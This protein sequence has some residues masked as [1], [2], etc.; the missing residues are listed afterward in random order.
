MCVHLC[1]CVGVGVCVA[2]SACISVHAEGVPRAWGRG[3]SASQ[4]G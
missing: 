4:A 1:V 3:E 2:L